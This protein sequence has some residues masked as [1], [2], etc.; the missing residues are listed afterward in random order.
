MKLYWKMCWCYIT[1]TLLAFLVIVKFA[2]HKPLKSVDYKFNETVFNDYVWPDGCSPGY[3]NITTIV[4]TNSTQT[5]IGQVIDDGFEPDIQSLGLLIS[6]SSTLLIPLIGMYQ[7]WKRTRKGKPLG[8]AMFRPTHHWKAAITASPSVQD[9]TEEVPKYDFKR[10]TSK[11]GSRKSFR[12]HLPPNA[13]T[14]VE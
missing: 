6:F 13:E 7:L 11:R 12:K 4:T 3:R 14:L 5:Q 8:M 9:I 2:Q 1:P 10:Q